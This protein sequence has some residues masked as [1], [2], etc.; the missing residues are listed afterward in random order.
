[1]FHLNNFAARRFF[2]LQFR[3]EILGYNDVGI[4]EFVLKIGNFLKNRP[5]YKK[6]QR[7]KK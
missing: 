7:V 6:I 4:S 1:M 5:I 3:L 2:S